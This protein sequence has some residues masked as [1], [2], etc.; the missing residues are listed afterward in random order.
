MTKEDQQFLA[1][2]IEQG[3]LDSELLRAKK[4]ALDIAAR[5]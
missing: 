5:E 4:G 2:L 1:A 3:T